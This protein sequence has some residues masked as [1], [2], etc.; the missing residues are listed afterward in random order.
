MENSEQ[1]SEKIEEIIE[2]RK[3][4]VVNWFKNPSNLA[5]AAIL[6][7]AFAIRLYYFLLIKNQPLWWDEACYG[8]LMKSWALD[9]W[10]TD[11][12]I[13]SEMLIRPLLFPLIWMILFKIGISEIGFRFLLEFVPSVL[14]VFLVYLIGKEMYGKKVGLI[15]AA[16]FSVLWIHL[17]YTVRLLTNIPALMF[18]FASIYFFV[19]AN[20]QGFN[21]KYLLF[22]IFLLSIATLIRYPVGMVFGVYLIV[23]FLS[24]KLSLLKKPKFWIFILIGIIPLL[25]FFLYNFIN[26]G[27]IFPA[28]LGGE[29]LKPPSEKL[30]TAPEPFHFEALNF[31]PIFLKTTFFIFFII[32]LGIAVLELFI[33]YNFILKNQR[34]RNHLLLLLIMLLINAFFIFYLKASED[35]WFFPTSI[36]MC[37][38]SALG[39]SCLYDYIKKYS[40]YIALLLV[41][42]ILIFGGYCQIS[43]ADELIKSRAGSFL[44]MRQGFEW[45]K[46]NSQE[47][48]VVAGNGIGA[49]S[50]YYAERGYMHLPPNKSEMWKVEQEAGFIVV[51]GFT[52][53]KEYINQYLQENQDKWY[54]INIFFHDEQQQRPALIIYKN[55]KII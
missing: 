48:D 53:Q 45:L 27:N 28:L 32:G 7:F 50:I 49:Y 24:K 35:R 9:K 8:S 52:P 31:I 21:L 46:E 10:A 18:L 29:Y 54:P 20:K 17:F 41:I 25:I 44:Q 40:K 30:G 6:V 38:F 15:A 3:T 11:Q 37:I 39:L 36:S 16:I 26:F 4:K 12:F 22:S 33:G 43:F 47:N 19:R 34:L 55:I 23:F 42:G 14:S 51:H 2:D 13:T 5:L 1:T